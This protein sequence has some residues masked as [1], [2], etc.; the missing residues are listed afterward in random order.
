M[1]DQET[2]LGNR[3][4]DYRREFATVATTNTKKTETHTER[5]ERIR[6]H[7]PKS[8]ADLFFG[9]P[10]EL[11]PILRTKVA[12]IGAELARLRVTGPVAETVA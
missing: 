3:A 5:M 11:V 4:G 6:D 8:D 1:T 7:G 9:V 2:T 12:G 10:D